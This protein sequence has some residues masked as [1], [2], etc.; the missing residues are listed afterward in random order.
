MA[1]F[2]LKRFTGLETLRSVHPDRL[3]S[4]LGRY[5]EYFGDRGVDV[6]PADGDPPDYEGIAGV[7]LAPDL[8][9]PTGLI[10]DLFFVD[11]MATHEGMESLLDAIAGLPAARRAE[12][13]TGPDPTPADVAVTVRLYAPE[14]IERRH[15]ESSI[16]SKRSY[17][18]F[19]P[20]N[21]NAVSSSGPSEDEIRKL[22]SVLDD[23]FDGMKYGRGTTV[24]VFEH[25]DE[26]CILVVRG[27]PCA[28]V[29]SHRTERHRSRHRS[30]AANGIPAGQARSRP[31]RGGPRRD[32]TRSTRG[33]R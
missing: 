2:T 13:D 30:R 31:G 17:Q 28:R 7:L 24:R 16:S 26:V 9:T 23:T 1:K 22:E 25:P 29:P 33:S 14:V 8:S 10:D 15:A 5:A 20:S 27:D 21:G 32:S 4:L 11:E 6:V 3:V 18:Y 19:S 12:L